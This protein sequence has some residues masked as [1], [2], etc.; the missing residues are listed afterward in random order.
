[1][2]TNELADLMGLSP[3]ERPTLNCVKVRG[4]TRATLVGL[5]TQFGAGLCTKSCC[6][7]F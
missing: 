2:D 5:T 6:N 4:Q 1:M 3:A 7:V